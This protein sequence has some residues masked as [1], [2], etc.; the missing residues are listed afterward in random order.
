LTF[1]E[2]S[3]S[4]LACMNEKLS[5]ARISAHELAGVDFWTPSVFLSGPFRAVADGRV[6]AIHMGKVSEVTEG[7]RI[8]HEMTRTPSLGIPES[9]TPDVDSAKEV[10]Y[11]QAH[12]R[13]LE[14]V[15]D[16][17][18]WFQKPRGTS[19]SLQPGDIVVTKLPPVRAA[20]VTE[21]LLQH[22]VDQ[23]CIVIRGLDTPTAVW[24]A[25]CFN[26]PAYGDYLLGLSGFGIL[27]RVGVRT[28]RELRLPGPPDL[29]KPLASDIKKEVDTR[30]QLRRAISELQKGVSD[31]VGNEGGEE[32]ETEAEVQ[33]QRPSWSTHVA[34]ESIDWSWA[35][36]H[37]AVGVL[38]SD[39]FRH[40]GW[41][42][43][44]D[45]LDRQ[46]H[47]RRRLS[48]SP[49]RRLRLIRLADAESSIMPACQW[50]E[51]TPALA[52][53]VY[54]RPLAEGEVLVSTLGTS[55][56]LLFAGAEP[57]GDVFLV[58]HW[59]RLLFSETPGAFALLMNASPVSGQLRR[60]AVGSARQF[61][62]AEDI[63]QLRIPQV[64][65]ELRERWD[66]S[67]RGIIAAWRK[68]CDRWEYLMA[69]ADRA[70]Q[71]VHVRASAAEAP[72]AKVAEGM[73]R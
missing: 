36:Q 66:R 9:L 29:F 32:L 43:V 67:A 41:I 4:V 6:G 14:V 23:S 15:P 69:Q 18:Q 39:I 34:A 3:N 48:S 73:T 16:P 52:F 31:W 54:R 64:P 20:M 46:P 19:A 49:P 68:S 26:H 33:F 55:P 12:I 63:Q 42:P 65:R 1:A 50:Q 5:I 11:R 25:V 45:V 60:M 71:R 47:D 10:T 8:T 21:E 2:V 17:E 70:F 37:V 51:V 44:S 59:E 38:Q 53:R 72:A 61:V 22:P 27:P 35:P 62:R 40:A 57:P 13:G 7:K 28:L 58:D 56:R 24:V 30:A